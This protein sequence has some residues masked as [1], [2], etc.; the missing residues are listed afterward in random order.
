MEILLH[1]WEGKDGSTM[2]IFNRT[3]ELNIRTMDISVVRIF[4]F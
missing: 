1:D 2:D 4:S 3:M